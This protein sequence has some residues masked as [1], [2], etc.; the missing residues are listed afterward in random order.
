MLVH[1]YLQIIQMCSIQI[2]TQH[3]ETI[4]LH[5]YGTHFTV[6]HFYLKS[7]CNCQL[8]LH[9]LLYSNNTQNCSTH[10]FQLCYIWILCVASELTID[11]GILR[12]TFALLLLYLYSDQLHLGSKTYITSGL[13][14]KILQYRHPLCK[15]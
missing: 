5:V 1:K 6:I 14:P 13:Q 4:H 8:H 12:C 15:I 11:F 10:L 9:D 3:K 2:Q 7:L